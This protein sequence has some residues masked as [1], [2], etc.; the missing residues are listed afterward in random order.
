MIQGQSSIDSQYSR[1]E[2]KSLKRGCHHLI[3]IVDNHKKKVENAII[4]SHTRK[5]HIYAQRQVN[6][7]M[8]LNN[9]S[10]SNSEMN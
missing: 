6:I 5:P 2:D 9:L 3:R 1:S 4:N 7:L 10:Q 8:K